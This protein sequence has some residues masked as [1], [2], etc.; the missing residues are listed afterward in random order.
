MTPLY[1]H[2]NNWA[3]R[4]FA[5]G[6][7]DCQ[8]F[9]ADWVL[10]ATGRDPAAEVRG[11]YYCLATCQ[12]VTGY[13]RDPVGTA[14]KHYEGIGLKRTS[15]PV[16]GDVGIACVYRD[17]MPWP[18]GAICLGKAWAFKGP[19]GVVAE[20]PKEIMAAWSVGYSDA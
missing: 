19:E 18:V 7:S 9:P 1:L 15:A 14:A 17:D 10:A 5:W 20:A 2:L 8:M 16:R 13:F 6:I 3:G 4:D 11:T 12:A